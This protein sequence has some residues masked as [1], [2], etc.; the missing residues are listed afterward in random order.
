MELFQA[1]LYS[2]SEQYQHKPTQS[3]DHRTATARPPRRGARWWLCAVIRGCTSSTKLWLSSVKCFPVSSS[4][5]VC[6]VPCCRV[7]PAPAPGHADTTTGIYYSISYSI[8]FHRGFE[9]LTSHKSF[10]FESVKKFA[11]SM[12]LYLIPD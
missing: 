6:V 5:G 10:T 8:F 2:H 7:H 9:C 12:S 11:Q 1:L 3:P 4:G